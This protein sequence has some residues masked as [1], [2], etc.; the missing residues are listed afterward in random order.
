MDSDRIMGRIWIIW[1]SFVS[2]CVFGFAWF[3][4]I[5]V[6]SKLYAWIFLGFGFN[7][8]L[9]SEK[10]LRLVFVSLVLIYRERVGPKGEC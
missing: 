2:I 8:I 4:W 1:T 3:I 7:G 6:L 9:N 5:P 10:D